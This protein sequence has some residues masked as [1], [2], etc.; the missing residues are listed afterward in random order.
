ME[1]RYA[2][3]TG[4]RV[5]SWDCCLLVQGHVPRLCTALI[6]TRVLKENSWDP[7]LA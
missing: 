6:L 1:G 2:S 7:L 3:Q 5:C 4:A